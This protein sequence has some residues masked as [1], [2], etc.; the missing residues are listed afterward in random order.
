LI[1]LKYISDAFGEYYDKLAADPLAEPEDRD[2]YTAENIFWVPAAARWSNLQ[3]NAKQPTIGKSIDD[4]MVEIEKEN[5]SLKGVLPKDYARP[6]LDKQ[7]LGELIDLIGTIGMGDRASRSKDIL[8]GVYE[9]FLGQFARDKFLFCQG[10]ILFG[11]LRPY[12]HKVGVA[13]IDGVCSTDIL[14]IVPKLP[15]WYSL[16]LSYVS[17]VEFIDYT[18]ATSTGTKMPRTNWHDMARYKIVIPTSEVAKG[19][20]DRVVPLLQAIRSNILQSRTLATIRDTLLPKLMSGE[21]RVK[22]AEEIL[23]AVA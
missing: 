12:F 23:E 22:E 10:D 16:V 5:P 4:A 19:F 15:N 13:V 20:N 8:G 21:I 2:E 9:F 11:K 3:N 1:F 6:S 17:S 14:V 18:N 7:L